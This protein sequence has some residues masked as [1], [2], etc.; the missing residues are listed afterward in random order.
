MTESETNTAIKKQAAKIIKKW[1]SEGLTI[2][3]TDIEQ[4]EQ[5]IRHELNALYKRKTYTNFTLA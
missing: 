4:F 5:D 1:K 3:D 2:T